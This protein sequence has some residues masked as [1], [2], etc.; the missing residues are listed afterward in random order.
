[1]KRNNNKGTTPFCHVLCLGMHS[2]VM[3]RFMVQAFQ[4]PPFCSSTVL[5]VC[6]LCTPLSLFI[7]FTYLSFILFPVFLSIEAILLF[8]PFIATSSLCT[9]PSLITL[10]SISPF[11][12]FSI[13]TLSYSTSCENSLPR[14]LQLHCKQFSINVIPIKIWPR[15]QL[16]ISKTEL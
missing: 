12:L 3:H 8:F 4:D 9:I 14:T 2:N 1:M 10:S 16:H 5:D 15:Y 11:V 13:R 6:S 7:F